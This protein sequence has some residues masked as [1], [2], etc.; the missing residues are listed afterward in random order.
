MNKEEYKKI[1]I[2]VIIATFIITILSN[3]KLPGYDKYFIFPITILTITCL[4]ILY[5][6]N[7]IINKKGYIYLIPLLLIILGTFFLKT[8]ISNMIINIFIIPII[9]SFLFFTLTN[10]NYCLS[11]KFINWFYKLFPDKLFSNLKV[12]KEN[13]D[14]NTE[15]KDTVKNILIGIL[16]SIP[17]VIVIIVLLRSADM[18]FSLFTEKVISYINFNT[19]KNNLLVLIISFIIIFST[20]IN[21]IKNKDYNVKESKIINANTTIANTILIII[22]LVFVLFIISEIS[23]LTINFLEIPQEYTYAKYAREGFFQLLFVTVINFSIILYYLYKTDAINKNKLLKILILLLIT[24]TI[25]L[26]FNSYYRMFLYIKAYTFT[27]LR[28]Q[29]ILFLLMELILLIIITKKII[30]NLKHNDAALFTWTILITYIINIYIC[31]ISAINLINSL[32]TK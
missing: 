32:I 19:I 15:K 13:Y 4:T 12:I 14:T 27:V 9:L 26:I 25:I 7:K 5:N 6:N 2:P 30:S 31:N 11:K 8:N 21:I 24:F 18:Y 1:I 16:I 20:T 10:K 28:T 29:V 3:F 23:K 17:I 22:N